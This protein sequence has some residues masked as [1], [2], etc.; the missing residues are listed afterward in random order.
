MGLGVLPMD[1]DILL[2]KA[3]HRTGGVHLGALPVL[4]LH[5]T[6]AK[7]KWQLQ[8]G[9]KNQPG[10]SVPE[11]GWGAPASV[12]NEAL[13]SSRARL[14]RITHLWERMAFDNVI[15]IPAV[16]SLI[17][18]WEPN[19]AAG[20]PRSPSGPTQCPPAVSCCLATCVLCQALSHQ[21]RKE[22]ERQR[23]LWPDSC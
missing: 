6:G 14:S 21:G 4:F 11:A 12:N 20:T 3:G 18:S 19:R 22:K 13:G 2:P 15:L 17:V 10:W 1:A 8:E 5:T 16:L 23:Q 9:N 7:C